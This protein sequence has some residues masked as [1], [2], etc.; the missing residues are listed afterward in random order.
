MTAG[1]LSGS[2][3]PPRA[4]GRSTR[5]TTRCAR[6]SWAATRSW[7]GS[8]WPTTRSASSAGRA[9]PAPRRGCSSTPR[10]AWGSGP[11]SA[12]TTTSSRPRGTRWSTRSP[13]QSGTVPGSRLLTGPEEAELVALRVL[14]DVPGLL[15][16][17][18]DV[19]RARAQ[20]QQSLQ[21]GVLVAVGGGDVDVQP[22]LA[23]R[24]LVDP[25]ED[26]RGRGAAEAGLRADLHLVV[27]L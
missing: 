17:L 8:R 7:P 16:G 5:W 20:V 4:T 14:Q 15:A 26:Q 11:P 22:Q 10:T 24:R 3:A 21:L 27:L 6:R 12:S 23:R 18:P 19:R 2:S 25:P 13:T 1:R 9:A